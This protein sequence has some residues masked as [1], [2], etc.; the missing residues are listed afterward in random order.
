MT[1]LQLRDDQWP[2]IH[3]FL[4]D[5]PNVYVGKNTYA[6]RRFVEAILWMSRR[7]VRRLRQLELCFKRYARWCGQG[8]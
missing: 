4:E 6:F 3:D 8:V 2:K 7:G 1:N 5:D